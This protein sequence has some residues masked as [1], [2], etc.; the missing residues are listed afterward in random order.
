MKKHPE[1]LVAGGAGYVGSHVARDL[2]AYGFTPL[3]ADNL[4][5][6]HRE[7]VVCGELLKGDLKDEFFLDRV[8]ENHSI[9]GVMHF[10][11]KCFVDESMSDPAIY[12]EENISSALTTLRAMLKHG[13]NNFIF[14]SSC[15]TY[16]NPVSLPLRETHPQDPVNPYGETKYF[17]ERI[18]KHYD[19]AYGLR[20]CALRYFNAAG[21][22]LDA[23]IGESHD[24][25]THLIPRILGTVTGKFE[26]IQIFG[27][28][29]PTSD[30]TCLR[31]YI[32][33]SD[34]ASAHRKALQW[35]S[36]N[37]A[38]EFF[39]LGT[40]TAYS[41]RQILES[42]QK[43]TGAEIPA[44]TAPR[45]PGDPPELVADPSKAMNILDWQPEYSDLDTIM[46]SAWKW[47]RI[48]RY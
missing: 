15:A 26:K 9:Q 39:N 17:I 42:A 16:G 24:P 11:G 36:E 7:A 13:V 33:V 14:S 30:G 37:D 48:R 6:G 18:L 19:R 41:V 43:T 5:K 21:A 29:Y 46:E 40:G 3:I 12:Y 8:F 35:I 31:D 28:D 38:S 47:E 2:H 34:L 23:R 10:A 25:E 1:I 27:D 45:R 20:F 22:S 4:S 44:E 32:H